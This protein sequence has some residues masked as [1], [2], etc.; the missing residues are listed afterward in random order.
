MKNKFFVLFMLFLG[1]G[2]FFLQGCGRKKVKRS[3][4]SKV[5]HIK[6]EKTEI[7]GD[8]MDYIEIVD[9]NY[10]ITTEPWGDDSAYNAFISIKIKGKKAVPDNM[11]NKKIP[12]IF[13]TMLD[14]KGKPVSN[15]QDFHL[16]SYGVDQRLL[17]LLKS[18]KGEDF[19]KF[20]VMT[21]SYN[22]ERDAEFVKKFFASSTIEDEAEE[23]KS[24]D[25]NQTE[26]TSNND[27]HNNKIDIKI[28][29]KID[30]Y[31]IN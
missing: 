29:D 9:N 3:P 6:P 11:L 18:G 2:I 28:I 20:Q 8:L 22:P 23:S 4:S 25:K 16:E 15:I 17:E 21:G 1:G 13:L 27:S 10:D 14:D 7:A 12:K 31:F 24:D 5:A 30:F 26:N 19:I